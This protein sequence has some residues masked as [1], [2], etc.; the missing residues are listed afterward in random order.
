MAG[1]L[2]I[3]KI[4]EQAASTVEKTSPAVKQ[5]VKPF[6]KI[7]SLK[8]LDPGQQKRD[9]LVARVSIS[10]MA[11][12]GPAPKGIKAGQPVAILH[13]EM[14]PVKQSLVSKLVSKI[15]APIAKIQQ[16]V[17]LSAPKIPAMKL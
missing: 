15:I 2:D 10:G 6:R 3:L 8:E 9:D 13:A 17:A 12:G 11:L 16:K 7:T 5:T 1:P 14:Q 4:A